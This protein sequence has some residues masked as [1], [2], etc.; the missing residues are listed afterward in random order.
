GHPPGWGTGGDKPELHDNIA[1]AQN[2]PQRI[3]FSP[4]QYAPADW[5]G[6][7]WLSLILHNVGAGKSLSVQF[8]DANQDAPPEPD[9]QV[10]W[11]IVRKHQTA[12]LRG[13]Y[14]AMGEE[15]T[16]MA[17]E[18]QRVTAAMKP[19]LRYGADE[20]HVSR[21]QQFASAIDEDAKQ[22]IGAQRFLQLAEAFFASQHPQT[23]R[24]S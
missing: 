16:Q 21:R 17:Q 9:E 1:A 5:D 4:S 20:P 6:R 18:R 14:E 22:P 2:G 12:F 11:R 7:I 8:V 19:Y 10:K 23:A 24:M 3:Q 13:A 15:S